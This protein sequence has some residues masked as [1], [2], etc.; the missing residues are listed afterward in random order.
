MQIS[1]HDERHG[2][3]NGAFG[4]PELIPSENQDVQM[5]NDEEEQVE[6]DEEKDIEMQQDEI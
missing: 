2:S 3:G 5:R 4:I 6:H 1:N